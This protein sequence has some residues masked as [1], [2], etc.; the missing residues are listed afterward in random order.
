[1]REKLDITLDLHEYALKLVTLT[2]DQYW[3]YG[4]TFKI[5]FSSYLIIAVLKESH[6]VN[7]NFATLAKQVFS[8]LCIPFQGFV[9]MAEYF[10]LEVVI[11]FC[12]QIFFIEHCNIE[13]IFAAF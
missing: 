10:Y 13:H 9:H 3:Q 6:F 2:I 4:R 12:T 1:M 5:I 11:Q 8:L 7:H